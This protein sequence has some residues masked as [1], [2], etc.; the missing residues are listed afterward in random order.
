[1][2]K[3]DVL[4][5]L[6]ENKEYVNICKK[7]LNGN[8]LYKDLYQDVM[9]IFIEYDD[10]KLN[11]LNNT[12]ELRYLYVR[13]LCNHVHSNSSPFHKKYRS[14]ID[15]KE[16]KAFLQTEANSESERY[17]VA[18]IAKNIVDKQY[19]F[20]KELF[21]LYIEKGSIREIEKETGIPRSTLHRILDETK[22]KIKTQMNPI[23]ILLILQADITALQYHRQIIPHQR[24][25]KTH[26]D[27]VK[28]TEIR[29]KKLED[30][31]TSEGTI[32]FISDDTLQSFDIVVYLRQ[33]SFS[34]GNVDRTIER[35]H[36]LGCKVILDIDDYWHL[37]KGHPLYPKYQNLNV[38]KETIASLQAVDAVTTTTRHFKT[39]LDEF[40]R[41]VTVL[42]NCI[43][44]D[45][46]QFTPR[47]ITN[48]RTRIG[49]IG[50]VHHKEDLE[51][52]R[53]L[54]SSRLL[55]DIDVK[56]KYQF[57]L[58]GFN[59]QR[60]PEQ[61]IQD[62]VNKG[63]NLH[64]LRN[65]RYD[66]IAIELQKNKLNLIDQPYIEI[67]R[68]MTNEYR[69][70]D[71]NY[72]MYLMHM[73]PVGEHI[74]HDKPYRRLHAKGVQ[75]YG[76]LYNEVD[77]CLAPLVANKFNHCKSELKIVEAGWMSKPVIV[78]DAPQYVDYIQD[79][80]NGFIVKETNNM[81]WFTSVRKL[82][83]DRSLR[84]KMGAALNETI[85]K[86]FDI[87]KHNLTRLQLYKSLCRK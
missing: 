47:E 53:H 85:K 56:D 18:D 58:G 81:K 20:N 50:G 64:T 74:S 15:E 57:C 25:L 38:A 13:I 60:M 80:V 84:E 55:K 43:S 52:I 79:G 54:F 76:E 51:M 24:L 27:E 39:I 75:A 71:I 29:G 30:G 36:R 59:Y 41:S 5:E 33:I 86:H 77:V 4:K 63:C 49:W 7:I 61:V 62:L 11:Q 48:Q 65:G 83:L 1:M 31:N 34:D 21:N 37:P 2:I 87:D 16:Y 22:Q 35:L 42:P 44:P 9:V 73:T 78:S 70:V 32:D 66:E 46:G 45:D 12:N 28:I 8:S 26:P 69:S 19:W 17:K 3:H 14:H 10:V 67:E 23:S 40:N 68:I 82:I 72:F 6:S